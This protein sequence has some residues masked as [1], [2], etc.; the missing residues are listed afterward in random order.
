MTERP[1]H[2]GPS[3]ALV[4]ASRT[5][6]CALA[7]PSTSGRCVSA[8]LVS[9]ITLAVYC[10]A[11]PAVA[12]FGGGLRGADVGREPVRLLRQ[13]GLV[14]RERLL[15]HAAIEQH[16]AVKLARGRE[17]TG[18]HR[19]LL[20]LVLGI[21]RGAHRLERLVMLAFGVQH[22]GRRDLLLDVDDLGPVGILGLAQLAASSASLAMSALA[23]PGLPE[24][25]APSARAKWVI[26]SA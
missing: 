10:F 24:R 25:A 22:P 15:G 26:A 14:G 13:H 2:A 1:A 23:A 21:G 16:G 6:T 19:M 3:V 4:S 20:G 18:R 5:R 12:G 8:S 9:A 11:F 7:T 17:R